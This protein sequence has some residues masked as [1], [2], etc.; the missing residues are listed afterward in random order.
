MRRIRIRGGQGA[1]TLIELLVALAVGMLVVQMAFASF[2]IVRK[3]VNRIQ[4]LDAA[5]KM[6]QTAV[7]WYGFNGAA[8]P[9]AELQWLAGVDYVSSPMVASPAGELKIRRLPHR[10]IAHLAPTGKL[11]MYDLSSAAREA[12]N[13]GETRGITGWQASPTP[14]PRLLAEIDLP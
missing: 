13:I 12:F 1:F 4:R 2:F 14:D 6:L 9:P 3:Y 5:S 7:S 11:T 8:A 10:I